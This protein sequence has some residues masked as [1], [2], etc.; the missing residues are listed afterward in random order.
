MTVQETFIETIGPLIRKEAIN[1]GYFVASP[2]IAQACLESNYGRSV[3][4]ARYF[5]YFG[6]KCGSSWKGKSVNLSTKEE[7]TTGVLTTIRDNFRV[8]NSAA[9]G[10][11]GYYDFISAKR[12]SNLKSAKSPYDYLTLIKADGYATSSTYVTSNM[13]VI[14]KYNLK[15]FDDFTPSFILKEANPYR[16]T[17]ATLKQ[18]SKGDGVKY[19]Q[20]ILKNKAGY[21]TLSVDGIFGPKTKENV[22]MFQKRVFPDNK[23]EWDGIVGA[24]TWE[25]LKKL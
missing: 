22:I 12:Y 17:S 6:L 13:N 18:G 23:K 3:L 5:N 8:Y 14:T 24:K 15:R 11:K 7:Y 9:E 16:A 1:R 4:S 10:V 25:K 21:G 2:V 19:L 20:W